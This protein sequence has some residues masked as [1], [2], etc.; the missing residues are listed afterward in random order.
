MIYLDYNATT[1]IDPLVADAMIPL[2]REHQA[3]PSSAHALGVSCREVIDKARGQVAALLGAQPDEIVF[4]SGGSE[5]NNHAIKGVAESLRDRGNH[6]ITC[7]VEHPATLAPCA[8]LER[9]G[10]EITKVPVDGNGWVDPDD[11]KRAITSRTILITIMHANNEVGTIQPIADISKIAREAGVLMHT[12]AAQSVGKIGTRVDELGVDLLSMASHKLYGP[13]GIGALY[14]RSGVT[15]E[16]LIHG[17]GHERGMR[18]GTES[19]HNTVGLGM[20]AELAADHIDSDELRSLSILLHDLI[21]DG[22]GDGVVRWNGDRENRLPNTVNLG[23]KGLVG[24]EFLTRLSGV[25]A[26]PGAACHFDRH[27]PSEVL[28]AMNVPHPFAL[29][30]IRFSLGRPTTRDDIERAAADTVKIARTLSPS[31]S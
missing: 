29:G 1:P 20:A 13:K 8:Y 17:A 16:P 5:S 30:S 19:T 15:I 24:P 2:L 14:V 28:S 10:F 6:I 27:E 26:S 4:T 21:V 25:A 31:S 9:Y 22:L 23:F 12:D 3:N 18:A 7:T 11:V